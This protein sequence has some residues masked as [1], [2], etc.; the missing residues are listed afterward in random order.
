MEYIYFS[1]KTA[2]VPQDAFLLSN[3]YLWPACI[4]ATPEG[5]DPL[6]LIYLYMFLAGLLV[7]LSPGFLHS[8]T[9]PNT[10]V[11][12][13][14]SQTWGGEGKRSKDTGVQIIYIQYQVAT[15]L[16]TIVLRPT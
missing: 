10:L 16:T 14:F 4:L 3:I 8:T 11:R 9:V 13:R 5:P 2:K 12:R 7:L 15:S 1:Y 6:R